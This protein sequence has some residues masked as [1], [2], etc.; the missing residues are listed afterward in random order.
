MNFFCAF[1]S[2]SLLWVIPGRSV[3]AQVK[4][5][6]L[7][8]QGLDI[9]QT[10]RSYPGTSDYWM[11]VGRFF[12]NQG[13]Y[14]ESVKYFKRAAD[15][16]FRTQSMPAAAVSLLAIAN[17]YKNLNQYDQSRRILNEVLVLNKKNNGDALAENHKLLGDVYLGLKQH[18]A[19][20]NAYMECLRLRRK[21]TP[22]ILIADAYVGI[23]RI[24][25]SRGNHMAAK[26][27]LEKAL[28]ILDNVRN[29]EMKRDALKMLTATYDALGDYKK[30]YAYQ[31]RYEQVNDSL[32]NLASN[33]ELLQITTTHEISIRE[34]EN[35]IL[36]KTSLLNQQII[37]R[38]KKQRR[39]LLFLMGCIVVATGIIFFGLFQK[40]K[41][42]AVLRNRYKTIKDQTAEITLKNGELNNA[43]DNLKT[44]QFR[45]IQS[46]KMASLGMLT[47]GIAHEINGPVGHIAGSVS[48][49]ENHMDDLKN[50][51]TGEH[52]ALVSSDIDMLMTTMR[53]GIYR[54]VG[55]VSGL[56]SFA[57]PDSVKK[58]K[59]DVVD[60]IESTLALL[61]N[62]TK[63]EI[64][65][66]KDLRPVPFALAS[67]GQINQVLLN[68]FDNAIYAIEDKGHR[69]GV[70]HVS[71]SF[72]D[73][74]IQIRIR[75]NGSGIS[76]KNHSKIFNPFF[77][78]KAIG[79]GT[80][81]GLYISYNIVRWYQGSLSFRSQEESGTEFIIEL[82]VER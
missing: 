18:Q 24:Y 21:N 5:D 29:A 32:R 73:N 43:L 12:Y 69:Q 31:L 45:L 46:E 56:N 53:N 48:D 76:E 10:V 51:L 79:K 23:G 3:T 15:E 38:Q 81:L 27:V 34:R 68:L 44:A 72:D 17:A 60:C 78:T 7:I 49:L 8:L 66:I 16:N 62:K 42:N 61:A 13:A 9:D 54:T 4:I 47:E 71:T 52:D 70:I 63:D 41:M 40:R 35:E 50:V 75:D 11:G 1:F 2:V 59:V 33:N 82:P 20:L 28:M 36:K 55:I 14:V 74:K 30:A 25:A 57:N 6:T 37:K 67:A 39:F 80:G 65:V 58:E 22:D 77:S 64:S 19:A 26:G